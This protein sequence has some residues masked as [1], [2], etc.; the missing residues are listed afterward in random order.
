M[1]TAGAS[2]SL[3]LAWDFAQ[4]CSARI[5]VE[6]TAP[7]N[8]SNGHGALRGKAAIEFE[9]AWLPGDRCAV[10]LGQDAAERKDRISVTIRY[11]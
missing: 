1:Q 3:V 9:D 8:R 4:L 2:R 10:G 5:S 6:N 11:L 7:G